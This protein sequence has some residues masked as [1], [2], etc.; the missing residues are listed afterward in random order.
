MSKSIYPIRLIERMPLGYSKPQ[1]ILFSDGNSYVV[2]FKNNPSG[3]R[4]LVNEYISG[5]LAQL[6]TLPIAPFQTVE[7]DQDFIHQ[8]ESFSKYNFHGGT[9]FACLYID[10]CKHLTFSNDISIQNREHLAGITA[11]DLWINNTDR[12]V[13]NV[14]LEPQQNDSYYMYMIDHGRIF[15]D[16]KWTIKT[17]DKKPKIKLKQDVHKWFISQLPHKSEIQTAIEKIQTL[18]NEEITKTIYSIPADWD[19]SDDEKAAV[20]SYLIE[21]KQFLSH[22]KWKKK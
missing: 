16:A 13:G 17:F 5:A 12:K 22:I 11:F 6:L 18:P 10:K 20:V 19:V 7:I 14:L 21:A 9:Q 4:I 15:A 2:K 8:Y 3:T 1:R